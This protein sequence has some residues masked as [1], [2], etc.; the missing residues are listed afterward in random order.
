MPLNN[1]TSISLP[2]GKTTLGFFPGGN[3]DYTGSWPTAKI[4]LEQ[5]LNTGGVTGHRIG[6]L[7]GIVGSGWSLTSYTNCRL[8][9]QNVDAQPL[10]SIPSLFPEY[11]LNEDGTNM[12]H[13]AGDSRPYQTSQSDPNYNRVYASYDWALSSALMKSRRLAI[14][15]ALG[16]DYP[17][18]SVRVG[19]ELGG[20]WFWSAY[21]RMATN[22]VTYQKM[23]DLISL[24]SS[25]LRQYWGGTWEINVEPF[26]NGGSIGKTDI[27]QIL[28]K[29]DPKWW[30]IAG[31]D[32]YDT[33]NTAAQQT[34]HVAGFAAQ[35]G[36]Y[37]KSVTDAAK[38]YNKRWAMSEWGVTKSYVGNYAMGDSPYYVQQVHSRAVDTSLAECAY[39]SYFNGNDW[40]G[41]TMTRRDSI[42]NPAS[43]T[44]GPWSNDPNFPD[45]ISYMKSYDMTEEGLT[46][47][48]VPQQPDQVP[49][50]TT[51]T[52][53]KRRHRSVG[54]T[55]FTRVSPSGP[56]P[57]AV[58]LPSGAVPQSLA[59]WSL[60]FN[61]DFDGSSVD[62]TKWSNLDGWSMNGMTAVA[63]NATVSGGVLSL[64]MS[65]A[66][67]GAYLSTENA[68]GYNFLVGDYFEARAYFP[69]DGT[70]IYGWPAVWTSG[71][72][73][74][75]NGELDVAEVGAKKVTANYHYGPAGP[76]SSQLGP[77]TPAGY[78][79]DAWHTYAVHRKSASEVNFYW[80]GNLV[81]TWTP[82]DS[83]GGHVL[84]LNSGAASTQ[85][86]GA[87][88]AL[89][90]DY[91][92]VWTPAV[93][94]GFGNTFAP[95]F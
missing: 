50:Q 39:L 32:A 9:W 30:D 15:Q 69:G 18:S 80:D 76:T 54:R 93:A 61:D 16:G 19:Q 43:L 3:Q 83:G 2:Y 62:L 42:A 91:V 37:I 66:T 68:W 70:N 75:S 28:N 46:R 35:A 86:L 52:S 55:Y 64:Q 5:W 22:G 79:G 71:Q 78:W 53:R 34:D 84:L 65:D 36:V 49:V 77:Y 94:Q 29:M 60:K 40:S 74:P 72:N 38:L 87:A 57:P 41:S 13:T 90:V 26:D 25:E 81:K 63:G 14:F 67:H 45:T 21:G 51:L 58:V 44:S 73:W 10:I 11:A 31:V 82:Q 88:G 24:M 12:M 33:C 23:A 1:Q 27:L 95:T 59:N 8:F 17:Y 89:K 20:N 92:R 6:M 48:S 4:Q 47:L 85:M 7:H 56:A